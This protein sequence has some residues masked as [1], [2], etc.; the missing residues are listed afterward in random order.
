M[1]TRQASLAVTVCV[2]GTMLPSMLIFGDK[3]NGRI[4]SKEF[5]T[6]STGCEYICEENGWMDE[7]AMLDFVENIHCNSTRKY[8]SAACVG[9]ILMPHYVIDD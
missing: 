1:G 8:H 6:F 7:G 5:P 3:Q 2:N 9:F 4:A